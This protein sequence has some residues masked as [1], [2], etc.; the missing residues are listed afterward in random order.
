MTRNSPHNDKLPIRRALIS[1]SDK[2]GII[3]FS[4]RLVKLGVELLSTGGTAALLR[5]HSMP[6]TEVATYTGQA[7]IMGGRVKTL[8]PKIH[9]GLLA[10]RGVDEAV[11]EEQGIPPIDLVVVN[12]YPFEQTVI[13]PDSCFS[14]AVEQIDIG[15]PAMLRSAAKN[16]DAVAVIVAPCDYRQVLDTLEANDAHLDRAIRFRLARK[17]F[18]H[19]AN[20]DANIANYLGALDKDGN[21]EAAFP[22]IWT[23]QFHLQTILRYG[24]N[25]H[26]EAAFY[27]EA[28]PAQGTLAAARPLQGK[29][30][31]YNNIADSD[32]A[33]ECVLQFSEPACVIVKHANPCGAALADTPL[34]AYQRAHACDPDS[35][36]GG[37]IALNRPL[38][39]ETATAILSQQFVEVIITPEATPE[40]TRVCA[41]KPMI[42]LLE[43]GWRCPDPA[44]PCAP[45]AQLNLK[46]VSGGVLLQDNDR[47]TGRNCNLH[48]AS[49]RPADENERRDLLFAWRVAKF[50]KSNAIVYCQAGQTKG[51]GAG[52]MSRVYS[53]RIAAIKARENGFEL[54]GAV[55]ASDAFFP[56]RDSVDQAAEL[57]ISAIIQPGG[58]RR[59]REVIAAANERDIAMLFTGVRHFLH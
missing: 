18:A 3:D 14:D 1:V 53:A 19:T 12:L 48:Q 56:F 25:P 43:C 40:A 27:S 44:T 50:V 28:N 39:E 46:R 49:E 4:Q 29:A 5:D 26:Q 15:G 35:A 30:L 22:E 52:Q 54:G 37:I 41:E 11:M 34:L 45:P 8:H 42:R 21:Q 20:Y 2:T 31:S 55:M 32:A 13:R 58:S 16:H 24:E 57:G 7:E 36:F 9:G 10:R 38:D 33:W 59:D 51:I 47:H 23:T 17:V 6:V